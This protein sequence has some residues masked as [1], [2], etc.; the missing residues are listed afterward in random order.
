MKETGAYSEKGGKGRRWKGRKGWEGGALANT[1]AESNGQ[2]NR[3][4]NIAQR[5]HGA[6]KKRVRASAR[7]K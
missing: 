3:G 5:K 2:Y 6:A 1:P 4:R 7:T